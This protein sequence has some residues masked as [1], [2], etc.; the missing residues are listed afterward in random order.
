M[1]SEWVYYAQMLAALASAK[2]IKGGLDPLTCPIYR[3]PA[4]MTKAGPNTPDCRSGLRLLP[5]VVVAVRYTAATPTPAKLRDPF[6]PFDTRPR[7]ARSGPGPS[8]GM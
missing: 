1:E 8:A 2:F 7:R 3:R 5:G 4:G 6:P